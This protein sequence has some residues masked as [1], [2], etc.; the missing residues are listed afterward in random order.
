[1]ALVF[2]LSL[3]TFAEKLKIQSVVWRLERY[4]ELS[5]LGSGEMLA[6]QLAPPRIMGDVEI[7]P[8]YH[9]DAAQVQ[10]LVESL[11]GAINSFYLY[12]PQS[13]YPQSDPTGAGLSDAVPLIHSLGSNNKSLRVKDLPPG[14]RLTAG[15]YLAF[16]YGSNPERRAFHRIVESVTANSGGATTL[17]EVRPHLRPGVAVDL[18]VILIKPSA[19]VFIVPG[20]FNPGKAAGP[21]TS[22]MSF[23]VMQRP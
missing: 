5:G 22:G 18:N 17:F 19:K 23:Q 9:S 14:Y 13:R 6:A 1:M 3:N 12:A 7:A 21:V 16:D 8:M 11:D 15:D 4:D 2:P 10:A 20:S